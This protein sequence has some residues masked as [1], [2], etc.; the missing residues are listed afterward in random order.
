MTGL[1]VTSMWYSTQK[2][3]TVNT[4]RSPIPS[5]FM[6]QGCLAVPI[7]C[8]ANSYPSKWQDVWHISH[9][10]PLKVEIT[11]VLRDQRW[12]K[13]NEI[14][15]SLTHLPVASFPPDHHGQSVKALCPLQNIL[16]V[17]HIRTYFNSVWC[18]KTRP[19]PC[20]AGTQRNGC[21]DA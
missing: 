2:F 14:R 3:P 20:W 8:S 6:Q 7:K 18:G 13:Q 19:W 1:S 16:E 5:V 4:H 15:M 12:P 17:G 10:L 11:T 9:F 21:F